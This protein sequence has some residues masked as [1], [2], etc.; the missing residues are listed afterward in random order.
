MTVTVLALL[1]ARSAL[2]AAPQISAPR[3]S[4]VTANT[5][6]LGAAVNPQGQ[7]TTIRFEYGTENCAQK[8]DPCTLAGEELLEAGSSPVTVQI[9]LVDLASV[10]VY[11]FV[12]EA[13]NAGGKERSADRVFATLAVQP[14]SPPDER[15]YEQASPVDKNGD[16]ARGQFALVKATTTGSGISFGS[17]FGI[18]GGKGAQEFPLYLAL[19]GSGELGWQTQGLLPP[20][21]FGERARVLGWLPD[22]SKTISNATR[23]G[24]PRRKALVEQSTAGGPA[25]VVAS[26]A[27]KAEYTYV[28][29]DADA[30]SVFFESEA[31]LPE[32]EGGKAVEGAIAG[33]P[34]LYVWDRASGKVSLAGALNQG[35]KAPPKGSLAG[36]YAWSRGINALTLRQ[37]GGS[38]G[39]YLQG[40]HAITASGDVYFTEI[41]SGKLYLRINP[42]QPQSAMEGEEC[43]E[44]EKACTIRVSASDRTVPDPAGSQ[45]AAFQAASA[46]GSRV[47]FTS[48]EKLTNDSNT[49]PDQPAAAIGAGS[50][51]TGE[52]EEPAFIKEHSIGIAAV[53]SDIYWADPSAGVIGRAKLDGSG[54]PVEVDKNF[55]ETG[56]SECEEEVEPGVVKPVQVA[57][58][59]RYVAV[60]SNNVYWTSSGRIEAESGEPA[61]GAGTIGRAELDSGGEPVKVD[62]DFIC[63]ASNPQ[64][65]AIGN[66]H[67]YWAN[68][69]NA[70]HIT[71]RSIGRAGIDGGEV[72]QEFFSTKQDPPVGV[73]V[74]DGHLYFSSRETSNDF[75]QRIPLEGGER[76][77]LYLGQQQDVRGVAIDGTNLDWSSRGESAI[78]RIPLASFP[79]GGSCEAIANCIYKFVD[80]IEG[81]L[82]GLA[83]DASH[84]YW[85]VNGEAPTN[86]GNDLYAYG[87]ATDELKDLTPDPNG[88]GAEVQGLLGTSSDGTHLY[89]AANGDLDGA[90]GAAPGDCHTPA[91]HGP[92]GQTSGSCNVYLWS[93]GEISYVGRVRAGGGDANNGVLDWSGTSNALFGS[94][95]DT[96]RTAFVSQDGETLLFRS[97]EKLT[98]YDNEGVPELYRFHVGD[99]GLRC[100]SC[101]PSGEAAGEGPRL[102]T[103]N[104][105]GPVS[106][107]TGGVA[108]IASRNLSSDGSRAFFETTEA[109]VPTDTNGQAGCLDRV[110]LDVYEWEAHGAGTCA[111][112]GPGY[113]PLNEGCL[114]LIS[115]GK[116]PYPSF[117]ADAS[118]NGDDVFFF[119][120][121]GLVG[122]DKDE[123]QDVYDSRVEGGLATQNQV[124]PVPCEGSEACQ[125]SV[126]LSPA[127][128]SPATSRFV[129]P[130][131][132]KQKRKKRKK[133]HKK[134]KGANTKGR[135]NR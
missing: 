88:N 71:V 23:L 58:I 113:S 118:E 57:S 115:S 121:Q 27:P 40:S 135:T 86:P 131:D 127:K 82:G 60:D 2:A 5:A 1:G 85:S 76:E 110:C 128:V 20:P 109:L 36:P 114:F 15:A 66:S 45:P 13:R 68:A 33:V 38:A 67:I 100:V 34:N 95:A 75:I 105:P 43:T 117:F 49:G 125:G 52:I 6:I 132:S 93:D 123:L 26:Y 69:G 39:Y 22:F 37:G 50:S 98:E 97:Q 134:R 31:K 130:T 41:G 122:Q 74:G 11:H 10:A 91:P 12:I 89:F 51:S 3:V 62:P 19:R 65:I 107:G 73:A 101:P 35:G 54:F 104:F 55:I 119:T 80:G 7:K 61:V 8:P 21:V 87:V 4:E 83:A 72:D 108:S 24:S 56:T 92:L 94:S 18:P 84:L 79:S 90:G 124:A 42:T 16:D 103:S 9:Q 96:P 129:G 28:G 112:G 81:E 106:P 99:A 47:F 44:P 133:T 32:R 53:G 17:S 102:G 63:G 46:D 64:G 30:S 78:G 14:N 59:P 25:T 126:P 111:M 120:R 116:S 29:A 48:P 70:G 77:F